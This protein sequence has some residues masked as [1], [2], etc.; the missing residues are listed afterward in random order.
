MSASAPL[1][2][3]LV[4]TG[5]M[6]RSWIRML[7]DS[8]TARIVGLVDL[9][10]ELAARVASEE[11]LSDVIIGESVADVADE[12]GA[13]AVINV[14]VPQAHRPVNESALRH[15]LPVLCEKPISG[16][17]PEALQQVALAEVTGKL[18]MVSQSRRYFNNLRALRDSVA[19][20]GQIS[21]ITTEF[22]HSDH[23]PGF[24][25]QMEHPLLVDM[26]IHHFDAMRYITDDVP[27]AV[28]GSA[29]N[30]SWS[31]FAGCASAAAEFELASGARYV[32]SGSRATPGM[33]TSWNGSWRIQA[34]HGA[35]KWDGDNA[36]QVDPPNPAP[37]G[38]VDGPE[39]MA[40][41]LEE[42]R[43]AIELGTTPQNEIHA[44]IMSLAMVEATVVSAANQGE[45][46]MIADLIEQAY[47]EAIATESRDDVRARLVSWGSAAAGLAAR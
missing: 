13:H 22:F 25:E 11:G 46:I 2:V 18:L 31:W 37:G 27:V 17:L 5:A 35:A 29:W 39:Q 24:R 36:P 3:V 8:S 10:L 47:A 20:L 19:G 26:S 44:N 32:Y 9:D 38:I 43:E 23:E 30:P 21:T 42:F 14:T 15:G 6:G 28:R 40:G 45:R 16:T 12:S 7:A 4:G 33:S 34:E 1:P 41:A